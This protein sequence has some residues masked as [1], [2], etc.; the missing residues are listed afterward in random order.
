MNFY[1]EKTDLLQI[2]LSPS[3]PYLLIL[4]HARLN[5]TTMLAKNEA[6]QKCLIQNHNPLYVS[7]VDD[8]MIYVHFSSM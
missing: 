3:N 1:C 5:G 8:D 7:N 4:A 2:E 6:T